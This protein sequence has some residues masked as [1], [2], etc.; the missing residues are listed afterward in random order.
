MNK[1]VELQHLGLI[2]YKLAWDYQT[3]LFDGVIQVKINNRTLLADHKK[4]TPNYLLFCQHPHVYT[5]GKSGSFEHLLINKDELNVHQA[6]FYKIN[7]GGDITYHGPGQL[8]VYP[9]FDLENFMTDIHK[10]LRTLEQ[11][12]I[13]TLQDYGLKAGRIEG[14]TGVWIDWD[15]SNPRK[16]CAIGVKTSRWVSM[17]GLAFNIDPDLT[18]FDHIVPC[19]IKNKAVTSLAAEL[20]QEVNWI[21]VRDK[22]AYYF[23]DLFDMQLKMGQPS[24]DDLVS[25]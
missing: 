6:S 21:E 1:S 10:Y 7:R 17:H 4:P 22:V 15:K 12:I 24:L 9:I 5:L 2:D 18:Y 19:G 20:K 11:V 25:H 13:L 3:H 16:I 8:V 14:L 23:E